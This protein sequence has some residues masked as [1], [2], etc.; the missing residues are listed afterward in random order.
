MLRDPSLAA[1]VASVPHAV[2]EVVEMAAWW[3]PP[4]LWEDEAKENGH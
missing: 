2:E 4:P 3:S 1:I